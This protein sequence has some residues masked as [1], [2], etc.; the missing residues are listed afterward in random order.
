MAELNDYKPIAAN[1]Y[2]G[3]VAMELLG[4]NAEQPRVQLLE[5]A[6][7]IVVEARHWLDEQLLDAYDEAF[8]DLLGED[9]NERLNE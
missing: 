8:D 3:G 4:L 2:L 5:H 6:N 7:R 9:D 1:S